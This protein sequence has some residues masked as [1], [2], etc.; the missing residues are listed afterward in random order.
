MKNL[1]GVILI[2]LLVG[3]TAGALLSL[4]KRF[5]GNLGWNT[6]YTWSKC[7]NDGEAGQDITNQYPDPDN[8]R[9]NHGPCSLDRAS[10][11]NSSL[12][13]ES[14]RIGSGLLSSITGG[15]QLS[16]IFN[17]Q[18]G[19]PLSVTSPGDLA[20]IGTGG[21]RAIQV[22]DPHLD[23]PTIDR[24][25][26]TAAFTPNTPGV[27]GNVGR[28]SMRGPKAWNFDTSFSRRFQV[29]EK[30][31]IELRAEAFNI[32]NHFN[33]GDPTTAINSSNFGKITSTGRDPRIMQFAVKYGF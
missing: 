29:T 30:Q 15:W 26:N 12:I 16:T 1:I 6:N 8:R 7:M 25:F 14:P 24:W 2:L 13:L 31:R 32:L 5:S 22:G 9:S 21:Q 23:N 27:W 28:N 4:Q 10:I 3:A 11:I 33:P 19:N 18:S 17:F 20:L